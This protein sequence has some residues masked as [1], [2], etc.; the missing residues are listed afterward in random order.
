VG[1]DPGPVGDAIS[2]FVFD[3]DFRWIQM[4]DGAGAIHCFRWARVADREFHRSSGI[5]CRPFDSILHRRCLNQATMC[6]QRR[7]SFAFFGLLMLCIEDAVRP[8]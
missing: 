5:G 6:D 4:K 2:L 8:A 3:P 7:F 1:G